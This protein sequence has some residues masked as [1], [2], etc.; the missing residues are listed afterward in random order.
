MVGNDLHE[1]RDVDVFEMIFRWDECEDL[2]SLWCFWAGDGPF[3]GSRLPN[4]P[5][6]WLSYREVSVSP[7]TS[8]R[9]RHIPSF[10]PAVSLTN[11]GAWMGFFSSFVLILRNN[12][13]QFIHVKGD[14]RKHYGE[15]Q[16]WEPALWLQTEHWNFYILFTFKPNL[17]FQIQSG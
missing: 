12:L 3:L 10:T 16:L 11:T 9:A 6:K 1:K 13:S 2:T 15:Q 5:Y 7:I 17:R 8:R 4:Q 14:N